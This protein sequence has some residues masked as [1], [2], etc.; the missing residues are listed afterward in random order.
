MATTN[1]PR[2]VKDVPAQEFVVALAQY[3]RSTGKV[4]VRLTTRREMRDARDRPRRGCRGRAKPSRARRTF[5]RVMRG[6]SGA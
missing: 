3:F 2:T 6:T 1:A 5:A 4:R